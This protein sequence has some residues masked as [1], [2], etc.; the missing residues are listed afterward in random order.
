MIKQRDAVGIAAFADD[1]VHQTDQKSTRL[2][3]NRLLQTLDYLLKDH[4]P[5]KQRSNIA[6]NIHL[7]ADKIQKRSLVI[8]FT[9]MFQNQSNEKAIFESNFASFRI[10]P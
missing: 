3:L 9:D 8:I 1:I 2:H 6:E 5:E 4:N 7:I 10:W